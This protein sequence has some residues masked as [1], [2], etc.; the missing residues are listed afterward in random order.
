MLELKAIKAARLDAHTEPLRK[1][2]PQ[3]HPNILE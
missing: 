3:T 2:I 1:K